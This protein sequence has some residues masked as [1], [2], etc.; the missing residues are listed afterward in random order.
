MA[1]HDIG[2]RVEAYRECDALLQVVEAARIAERDT[3]TADVV[4][5]ARAEVV[6]P[7]LTRQIERLSSELECG[8]VM[9]GQHLVARELG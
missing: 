3:C 4:E 8:V 1:A 2:N 9:V 5:R 6:E 7:E